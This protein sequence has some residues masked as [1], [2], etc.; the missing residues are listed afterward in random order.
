MNTAKYLKQSKESRMKN[1]HNNCDE[2]QEISYDK[3]FTA[4]E[5]SEIKDT[6]A[7]QSIQL[8]DVTEE[9]RDVKQSFADEMAPMKQNIKHAIGHLKSGKRLV[10]EPC[11]KFLDK[12]NKE[13]GYY[14]EDGELV[15]SRPANLDEMQLKLPLDKTEY[16]RVPQLD[17]EGYEVSVKAE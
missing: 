17:G 6:L 9:F 2:V 8:F 10:T 16:Q 4:T 5:L 14:N 13:V 3:K 12:D 15:F 1:L 11:F 7:D